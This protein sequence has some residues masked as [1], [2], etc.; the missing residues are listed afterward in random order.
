MTAD[1]VGSMGEPGMVQVSAFGVDHCFREG[2]IGVEIASEFNMLDYADRRL[3]RCNDLHC[4]DRNAVIESSWL[5]CA[6]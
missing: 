4:G 6:L 3:M 2:S 5:T 1:P